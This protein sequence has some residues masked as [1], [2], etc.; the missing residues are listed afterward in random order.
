[1]SRR[2][3]NTRPELIELVA[4]AALT[5]AAARLMHALPT[6][7]DDGGRCPASPAFIAGAVFF[8]RP[9]QH[10]VIG[11]LLSELQASGL[12]KLYEAPEGKFLE[13]VGWTD[14][15]HPNYQFIKRPQ[16]P[17][18]PA[19]TTISAP[20]VVHT[21]AQIG[22]TD[23]DRDKDRDPERD[24]RPPVQSLPPKPPEPDPEQS[25]RQDLRQRK[26]AEFDAM[27]REVAGILGKR[28]RPLLAFDQG[29][30]ELAARIVESGDSAEAHVDHVLAIA[31]AEALAKETMQFLTG[32]IFGK[33]SWRRAHGMELDDIADL[34]R[35]GP[36]SAPPDR[37]VPAVREQDDEP[38][39][40]YG[41]IGAAK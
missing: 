30:T 29:Q 34:A 17:R 10:H 9:K 1:M 35:R 32:A 6:L 7:C 22:T 4:F 33:P 15:S 37:I 41:L 14:K 25:A 13:V 38:D 27:R 8:A 3:R 11:Q 12:V 28:Y 36:I 39:F 5:D 24:R 20:A 19:P 18:Y 31:R 21:N 23:K 2:I 40:T 16:P 26:W